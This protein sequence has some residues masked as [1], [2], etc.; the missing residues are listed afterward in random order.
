M[1]SRPAIVGLTLSLLVGGVQFVR[2]THLYDWS[3]A[4]DA[5]STSSAAAPPVDD[6]ALAVQLDRANDRDDIACRPTDPAHPSEQTCS[7]EDG[8]GWTVL[9]TPAGYTVRASTP[10]VYLRSA[11]LDLAVAT[12]AVRQCSRMSGHLP[13]SVHGRA[14][15]IQLTC[16]GGRMTVYLRPGDRLHYRRIN[17]SRYHLRVTASDGESAVA[18]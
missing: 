5:Q 18:R 2:V 15:R 4:A 1:R 8:A 17:S 6:A 13:S 11:R 16:A 12:Q 7:A 14:G 9:V 10:S 3:S